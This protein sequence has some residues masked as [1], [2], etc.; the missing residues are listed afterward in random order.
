MYFALVIPIQVGPR[1]KGEDVVVAFFLAWMPRFLSKVGPAGV[2]T[3]LFLTVALGVASLLILALMIASGL[4]SIYAVLPCYGLAQGVGLAVTAYP[5]KDAFTSYLP[6]H[7][8]AETF[9][10]FKV[11]SI[12]LLI[13]LA[14][15]LVDLLI[16][17]KQRFLP[18]ATIY[19]MQVQ[20]D[21]LGAVS[22]VGYYLLLVI[23]YRIT[24]KYVAPAIQEF[25]RALLFLKA[26]IQSVLGFLIVYLVIIAWFAT[27]YFAIYE[28]AG[29]RAFTGV[30]QRGLH[31]QFLT[32]SMMVMSAQGFS[33]IKP[34]TLWTQDLAV[35]QW[36]MG[37]FWTVVVFGVV[38]ARAAQLLFPQLGKAQSGEEELRA[39]LAVKSA[40]ILTLQAQLKVALLDRDFSSNG[41]DSTVI[42]AT[43]SVHRRRKRRR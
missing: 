41:R 9:K 5:N 8:P 10:R 17:A 7:S 29:I 33:S 34:V 32:Y 1:S 4:A 13:L 16:G 12:L 3:R 40:E 31:W 11:R 36:G 39:Q 14:V 24:A 30:S 38:L 37:L 28:A 19:G 15:C 27:L 25:T 18:M 2:G 23:G 21:V 26:M 20:L 6:K 42:N 22:I 43:T 35:L